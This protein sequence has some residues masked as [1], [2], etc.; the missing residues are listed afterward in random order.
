MPARL[1]LLLLALL[2]A[3]LRVSDREGWS[4]ERRG[5]GRG[6]SRERG[7]GGPRLRA[8]GRRRRLAGSGGFLTGRSGGHGRPRRGVRHPG[9]S[10]ASAAVTSSAYPAVCS[11][12]QLCVVLAA[13]WGLQKAPGP[14]EAAPPAE[15]FPPVGANSAWRWPRRKGRKGPVTKGKGMSCVCNLSLNFSK[16]EN[17]G[18]RMPL[19]VGKRSYPRA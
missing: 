13:P 11:P 7:G 17:F 9:A 12:A 2:L 15:P 19:E 6:P 10:R 18:K 1:Q 14:W 4:G 3:S 16:C 5:T 8:P